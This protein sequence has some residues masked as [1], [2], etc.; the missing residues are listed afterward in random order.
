MGNA[1]PCAPVWLLQVWS[2]LPCES[3]AFQHPPAL[4]DPSRELTWAAEPWARLG[5]DPGKATSASLQSF[6]SSSHFRLAQGC[7]GTPG[8]AKPDAQG[9]TPFP[10]PQWV[11][12]PNVSRSVKDPDENK[13]S[14]P[15]LGVDRAR[16][17][18]QC[19]THSSSR[20]PYSSSGK[21]LPLLSPFHI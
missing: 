5:S 7:E 6:C 18:S 13:S 15:V 3:W 2:T 16:P 21:R 12:S 19:F 1:S 11:V 10:K 4:G 8:P 9:G 17:G 20:D 14:P